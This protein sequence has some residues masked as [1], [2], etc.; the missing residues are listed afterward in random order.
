MKMLGCVLAI[1]LAA[2]AAPAN[3]QCLRQRVY[4]GRP[5]YTGLAPYSGSGFYNGPYTAG[6]AGYTSYSINSPYYARRPSYPQSSRTAV[7]PRYG[8]QTTYFRAP[9]GA[10]APPGGTF[11]G[12]YDY[13]VT[14][15]V[16]WYA[17]NWTWW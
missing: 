2:W 1:A 17:G 15:P 14:Y 16:D 4:Y 6:Y 5:V 3:A 11:F 13:Q 12:G 8:A 10:Y 7:A 9:P